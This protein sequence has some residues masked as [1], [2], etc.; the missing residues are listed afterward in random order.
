[1][2]R[3][4]TRSKAT[5]DVVIKKSLEEG[6]GL[7]VTEAMWKQR[8]VVASAVGGRR[9]QIE[10]G[11]NG[12]LIRDPRVLEEAGM[13]IANLLADPTRA[14]RLGTAARRRVQRRFLPDRHPRA[15]DVAAHRRRTNYEP[16]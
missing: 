11:V 2:P 6:F 16:P 14:R 3:L 5:P 9:K 7:G 12:L 1:M 4:S 8:A 13:A 15:M 10:H